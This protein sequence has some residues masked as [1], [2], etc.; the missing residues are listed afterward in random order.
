MAKAKTTERSQLF[1]KYRERYQKGGC[2]KE[3][4]KRIVSLGRLTPEEYKEITGEDY[5]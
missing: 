2:T 1:E 4:L 3:Q 5:E